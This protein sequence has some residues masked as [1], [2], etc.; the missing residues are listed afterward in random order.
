MNQEEV[1]GSIVTLEEIR[2]NIDK[3]VNNLEALASDVITTLSVYTSPCDGEPESPIEEVHGDLVAMLTTATSRLN[4]VCRRL[5]NMRESSIFCESNI[6]DIVSK[7]TASESTMTVVSSY[8][9]KISSFSKAAN[10]VIEAMDDT[11]HIY[12][13]VIISN[14][15]TPVT[16]ICN[17]LE[18]MSMHEA[19]TYIL[20][21]IGEASDR[22]QYLV[23]NSIS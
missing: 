5:D 19:V 10:R 22:M 1:K 17:S 18:D 7:T 14:E 16:G 13:R 23:E 6:A 4:S 20:C 9:E 15:E 12:G 11:Y 2:S 3:K 21:K 8:I